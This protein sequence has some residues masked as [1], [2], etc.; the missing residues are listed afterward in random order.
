M[1]EDDLAIR[2]AKNIRIYRRIRELSQEQLAAGAGLHRTQLAVIERGRRNMTLKSL[3]RIATAL[4]VD[5]RDL[6]KPPDEF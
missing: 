5:P 6:L 4:E 1:A 2:V 3:Q